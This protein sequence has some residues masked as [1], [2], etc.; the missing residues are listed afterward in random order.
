VF[1]AVVYRPPDSPV[2]AFKDLITSMQDKIDELSA[3]RRVP[4]MFI[5]GD[6]NFPNIDWENGSPS[7]DESEQ[8]LMKFIDSNFL[9]QVIREP[10]R[11]SN[12]LDLVITNKPQYVVE[13][14]TLT[15]TLS[16]HKIVEV[17]LGCN[18]LDKDKDLANSMQD[19]DPLSFRAVNCHEADFL[20]MKEEL[21][22][23]D[24]DE[25]YQL[26]DDD[27][28]GSLFL[29]LF[30]LTVLQ[31]TL[32]HAPPKVHAAGS[33]HSKMEREKYTLKR[34]RRKL[35][36]EIRSLQETH[37][38]SQKLPKLKDKVNLLAYEISETIIKDLN[39][40]EAKA[41][42]TVK[43]NPRYFYSYAKRFS[44]TKSTVSPLRDEDGRITN[45]PQRKAELLQEQYAKVF[46]NPDEVNVAECLSN[47]N[48]NLDDDT[49]LDTFN[50]TEEDIIKALK[51]LD[52]YSATP[53]GDIPA[54]I[55]V[56]CKEQL[57]V[58][59]KLM[60]T[61]SLEDATIPASL[62]NQYITPLYKKGNRTDPANYRPVSITSHLIKTFERVLRNHMVHH[63]ESNNLLSNSQHGFRQK[64]SC[65]TQLIEHVEHIYS[66]LN[67][68][69][70]VDVIYLDYAK[71]F[72]KV[73]HN[74]LLA[75]LKKYGI[76]GKVHRWI[77]EFLRVRVQI[78][79]VEGKK[80]TIRIVISGVPQ[81][82][83]LGPILF[84]LYINDLIEVLLHSKGLSFADDTKLSK[85]IRDMQ[86]VAL[87]QEDLWQV[88]NWS[89]MNNMLLHEKKFE[90][91]NYTLN[92][93]SLLRQLPFTSSCLE[94]T[95]SQGHVITPTKTVRDLGVLLSSD[96]SWSSHIEQT[97]Q[98]A[99]TMA[100]WVL[101]VFRDRSPFIMLT[102]YKTMVR[103]RLEYCCPVWNPSKMQDIQALENVQRNFTRKISGCKGLD[104]WER[105]KRL[106]LLSL[107][108]RRERYSIIQVWKMLN[109]LAPNTI[110][111]VFYEHDR[112]GKKATLPPVN[113]KA[114]SAVKTDYE[115]S[116]RI[117]S[118]RLWNILPK[119]INTVTT[120][121][122]FKSVLGDYLRKVP[123]T[124]PA[125]GYTAANRNSLLDWSNERGGRT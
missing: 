116:F 120:L 21:S 24:W 117:K 75:K 73:D 53:D 50:L 110:N 86:S 114:Q 108:R 57:A 56:S 59:L 11:S 42:G 112:L 67:K 2:S 95:T 19:I 97:V 6:F 30:L 26:C 84:I 55:L 46:S 80:S 109:G 45:D 102:L 103:S 54:R 125:P 90:V 8:L 60:W 43:S 122:A 106:N 36:A 88:I 4:E 14:S 34:R 23:I 39:A 17:L 1:F 51:E 77:K 66:C 69:E 93:S 79:V 29:E 111:I 70:E 68:G 48:P 82:T 28:D 100:S 37:P 119:H 18:L 40:K 63:L 31:I 49:E 92:A 47:I 99:R 9:S 104:Y 12:I 87:L 15:T 96:R 20:N 72:D 32:H 107:Q 124:P 61:K 98:S 89:Q 7:Y 13:T 71:A 105:L 22:A 33:R 121:D 25:L 38:S 41:V 94:Y 64:R 3:N 83:V 101:S 52:P 58:P 35:N 44:K 85:A 16:D 91:L 10:T 62:K 118:S 76:R 5:T 78:V 113:H 115:N 27:P 74:I 65:L 123:D 81:G